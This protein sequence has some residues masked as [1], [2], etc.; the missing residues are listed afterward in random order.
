MS[1]ETVH[2]L[3]SEAQIQAR[4]D[5]LANVIAKV[6]P[7]EMTFVGLL[8]GSFMFAADLIRALDAKGL[9]PKIEFLQV[10]SYGL[11]KESSGKV[12]VIGGMPGAIDGQ[13]VLLVDDIQDT[14][15]TLQ[16][17]VDLLRE[18]G[19]G[20]V[21]TCT[22]LDKPSRRVVDI[23]PDFVGFKIEDVFVVGYGIDYAERY[24]HLPYI[25]VVS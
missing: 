16:F 10:S 24:R 25:G 15:R 14:G 20:R 9:R 4:V 6:M 18:H 11:E 23:E 8:K 22:L 3:Y 17:T 1:Q 5:E 21:W 13:P 2:A 12:K 7:Q 19:A